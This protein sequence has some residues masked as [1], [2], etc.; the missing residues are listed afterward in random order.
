MSAAGGESVE[1]GSATGN[2][3]Q[4]PPNPSLLAQVGFG[5]MGSKTLLSA[6]ELELFTKLGERHDR[7]PDR[8][9]SRARCARG[10]GL[11]RRPGRARLARTRGRRRGSRLRQHAGDGR[12]PRQGK[13]TY[14]GG[15][16]EM[17]NA[18]LYR[19]WGDLTEAPA[20]GEPQNEVKHTGTAMFEE[21]YS[22]P[23]RLEQFMARDGR[24]LDGQL[25]GAGRE[26]RLLA[27]RDAVRRR[28]RHRAA[29][30]RWSPGATRICAAPASTCRSSSRSRSERSRRRG[31]LTGSSA[32][33]RLLR[34][35]AARRPT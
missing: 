9:R 8:S 18:R 11:P 27:L 24:D 25:H 31:W 12:L 7:G 14:I 29:L 1:Q 28:R 33:R 21:L 19:F 15:I 30:D 32:R 22:D 2:G 26:V 6:V 34:R 17:A 23:A 3:G 13:P 4:A 20:T 16:L 35:S 10:P 5:F